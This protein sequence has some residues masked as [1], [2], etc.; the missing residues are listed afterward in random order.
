MSWMLLVMLLL[1]SKFPPCGSCPCVILPGEDLSQPATMVPR[2]QRE[3]AAIFAGRVVTVDTISMG[4]TWLPSDTAQSR[5]LLRWADT[6]RYTFQ[7]S[8]TWK[9][10]RGQATVVTVPSAHSSCGR[11]FDVGEMYLV[12]A[13]R[14]GVASSCARVQRLAEAGADLAIL[15]KG[16]SPQ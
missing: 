4:Q 6:V 9:G 11:S 14:G 2:A 15:G 16:Q 8:A 12:Y 1:F 13:E 5:R 7:V 3:A 10:K